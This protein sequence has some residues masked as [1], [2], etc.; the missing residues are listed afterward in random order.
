MLGFFRLDE[1]TASRNRQVELHSFDAVPVHQLLE[2]GAL[3]FADFRGTEA[4]PPLSYRV[5]RVHAAVVAQS[6]GSEK[7]HALVVSAVDE[8]LQRIESAFLEAFHVVP[9]AP[10]RCL[11]ERHHVGANCSATSEG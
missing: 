7:I 6:H 1:G 10:V 11:L 5:G 3:A 2:D 4:P 8:Q 9:G